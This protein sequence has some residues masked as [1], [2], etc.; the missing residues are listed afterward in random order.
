MNL[1]VTVKTWEMIVD[2]I[3]IDKRDSLKLKIE[4]Y[5]QTMKIITKDILKSLFLYMIV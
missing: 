4:I 3:P 5:Y 2:L 1:E